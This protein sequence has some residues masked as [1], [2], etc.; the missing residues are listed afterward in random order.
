VRCTITTDE[1][2]QRSRDKLVQADRDTRGKALKFCHIPPIIDDET[3]CPTKSRMPTLGAMCIDSYRSVSRKPTL[4]RDS[5]NAPL[6]L[7]TPENRNHSTPHSTPRGTPHSTPR[8]TPPST[9]RSTFLNKRD[10]KAP[11]RCSINTNPFLQTRTNL[12]SIS[13][14]FFIFLIFYYFY[15]FLALHVPNYICPWDRTAWELRGK[16]IRTTRSLSFQ[17]YAAEG[18]GGAP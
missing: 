8:G 6:L 1:G 17:P 10:S 14:L 13:V 3:R 7:R 5:R 11:H 9:P 18:R 16:S 4:A 12:L 2:T 15:I